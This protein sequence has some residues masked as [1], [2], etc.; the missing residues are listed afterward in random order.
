MRSHAQS[1]LLIFNFY[2]KKTEVRRH[3]YSSIFNRPSSLVAHQ[4]VRPDPSTPLRYVQDDRIKHQ[5]TIYAI[6]SP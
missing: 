4:Y 1:I 3:Y 6:H 2:I 5:F